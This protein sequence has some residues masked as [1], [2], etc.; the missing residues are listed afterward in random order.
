MANDNKL[1]RKGSH[2]HGKFNGPMSWI[3]WKMHPDF[4]FRSLTILSVHNEKD[5][6]RLKWPKSYENHKARFPNLSVFIG[7]KAILHYHY[8]QNVKNGIQIRFY[9]INNESVTHFSQFIPLKVTK[10]VRKSQAQ[11]W[12]KLRKLTLRQNDGFLI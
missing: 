7:Q 5:K 1:L 6:M 8:I 9:K 12:E 10:I 4:S 11:F 2:I 3:V